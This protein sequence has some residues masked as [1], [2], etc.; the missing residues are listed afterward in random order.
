MYAH[1]LMPATPESYEIEMLRCLENLSGRVIHLPSEFPQFESAT[2]RY[3]TSFSKDLASRIERCTFERNERDRLREMVP[4]FVTMSEGGQGVT[5]A[6][7]TKEVEVPCR[8]GLW[9]TNEVRYETV[10]S[11]AKVK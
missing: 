9:R 1:F 7:S 3:L 5:L 4:K 6:V 10:V 11:L 2:F 8:R